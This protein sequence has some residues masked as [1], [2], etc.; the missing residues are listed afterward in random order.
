MVRLRGGAAMAAPAVFTVGTGAS[1]CEQGTGGAAQPKGTEAGDAAHG[2]EFSG[3]TRGAV[4]HA[5]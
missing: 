2:A 3:L 1:G 4:R 5:C